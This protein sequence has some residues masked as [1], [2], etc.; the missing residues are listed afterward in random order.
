[1]NA[2][3]RPTQDDGIR[4]DWTVAEVEALYALPFADLMFEAQQVH[5]RWHA[6]NTVQMSSR[7]R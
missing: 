2:A 3:L 6:P 7:C 4:H 1:M 5:R